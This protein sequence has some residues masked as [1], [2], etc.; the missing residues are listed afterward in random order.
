M[1]VHG[2]LIGFRPFGG[3]EVDVQRL[4]KP[5]RRHRLALQIAVDKAE[6]TI[7]ILQR[8]VERFNKQAVI[9]QVDIAF[10]GN[11]RAV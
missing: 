10:G 1:Q 5:V 9:T 8:A 11:Q 2:Y 3:G 6:F 7:Q 4:I